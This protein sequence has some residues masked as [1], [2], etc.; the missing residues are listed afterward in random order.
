M[1]LVDEMK[2]QAIRPALMVDVPAITPI[3]RQ[4]FERYVPLI[5]RPPASMRANFS[6]HVLED[7]VFIS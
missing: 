6:K 1:T 5:G 7:T 4:S 3:A 2:L